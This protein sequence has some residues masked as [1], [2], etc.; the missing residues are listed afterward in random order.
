MSQRWKTA[1]VV[2]AT[3]L[4]LTAC[5]SPGSPGA[6]AQEG[7]GGTAAEAYKVG[8]VYSKSGPLASYGEQYRQGFTA[9]LDHATKG[10]GEVNGH[11]IEVTEQDDASDPAK[12]TSAVTSLVGQGAKVIAGSTASGVALQVAPLAK[13]NKVLF[14]SGPAAADGVTGANKY[15]FRSGRQTFQD[16]TTAGSMIGDVKGRKVTVFAQ[17]SAFGKANEAGVKAI[18]GAKGATVTSVLAPAA[19]T[20]LTPF[21]TQIKRQK[22]DLLFVAWAGTNASTMWQTL[23]QQGV[24]A[25]TKVVT[26]LDIKAT[27]ALFGSAGDKIDF[28]SHFFDGA[29]DN[30]AYQALEA[31]MKKQ[32]G[33]VDLFTHDGFTAAQMVVRALTEGGSDVDKMVSALEGWTFEG[34]KGSMEIRAE[35]HAL[36]QPMFTVKLVKDGTGF[37]PELVKTLDPAAVAPPVTPFK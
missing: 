30:P 13:D 35:D 31:G 1:V 9:G 23:D 29:A 22:P 11:K 18:L 37:K 36:L 21:A 26:G 14:I 6:A 33:T 16:I 28:L 7:D 32:G 24:F 17:D 27:H 2:A 4:A 12:A 19:A 25:T 5:G 10:S 20:D 15:T 8:L 34:P 3:G